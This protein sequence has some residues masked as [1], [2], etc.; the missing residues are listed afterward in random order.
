M[1]IR[2]YKKAKSLIDPFAFEEYRKKKIREKIEQDRGNR[3][4]ISKLPN[5]NKDLALK[6]M[7]DQMKNDRKKQKKAEDLLTDNRFK[8]LFENPDFQVDKNA[9]EYR[10][11]NPVL[12]RLDKSR[13]KELKQQLKEQQQQEDELEVREVILFVNNMKRITV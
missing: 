4:Q 8:Q 10:L 6:L 2:L 11:L 1:D 13:K 3:V 5:V 9:D 12:A 7:D